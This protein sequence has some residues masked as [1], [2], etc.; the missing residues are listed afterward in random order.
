MGHIWLK[1][2]TVVNCFSCASIFALSIK[3]N[4]KGGNDNKHYFCQQ[5]PSMGQTQFREEIQKQSLE[6][7]SFVLLINT[8]PGSL[9]FVSTKCSIAIMDKFG[10][11][12]SRS[13]FS[14]CKIQSHHDQGDLWVCEFADMFLHVSD[15]C[16]FV[17]TPF[18]L[19]DCAHECL[20]RFG[21]FLAELKDFFE[22]PAVK[23][24]IWWHS[25][26]N[27]KQ[28]HVCEGCALC[29]LIHK[30]LAF[31]L[32]II[33]LESV[34][35]VANCHQIAITTSMVSAL[36]LKGWLVGEKKNLQVRMKCT[37]YWIFI[38]CII[39]MYP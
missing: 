17:W 15:F 27:R 30:Q 16:G 14:Q 3:R 7:F 38:D 25:N 22:G 24:R 12:Y 10:C 34:D 4:N 8:Q 31:R 9:E 39:R 37:G 35:C 28:I 32:Q 29:K 21:A 2:S 6:S 26:P 36:N 33:A 1:V 11:L 5:I 23:M 18:H 19:S 20:W 13:S